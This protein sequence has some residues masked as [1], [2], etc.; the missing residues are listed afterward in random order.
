MPHHRGPV[1]VTHT[2][3]ISAS[4]GDAA[5]GGMERHVLDLVGS[6]VARGVD[7]ELLVL[8]SES[9]ERVFARLDAL[10]TRVPV[11]L[12]WLDQRRPLWTARRRFPLQALA[13]ARA[14]AARSSRLLHIHVGVADFLQV[15]VARLFGN[16][17]V[18]SQHS[19]T[20]AFRRR[21]W[22]AAMRI[23]DPLV[24]RYIAV[25]DA[26]R[27]SLIDDVGIAEQKIRLVDYGIPP[28][29]P[30]HD[31]ATLRAALGL[32][33]GAFVVGYLG[34]LV[35]MKN[36]DCLVEAVARVPEVFLAI[37]GD[38]ADRDAIEAHAR[39][40]GAKNVRFLGYRTDSRE[41][42]TAF[43][44]AVLVSDWEGKPLSLIEAMLAGVPVLG[45]A[46][47]GTSEALLHGA[48]GLLVPRRDVDALAIA[49]RRAA[50]APAEM[51]ML[52]ARACQHATDAFSSARMTDEVVRV[53][54]DVW[55]TKRGGA[56]HL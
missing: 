38:G 2:L 10:R 1:R 13:L 49:L 46:V 30:S 20:P 17:V 35:A 9:N 32:P 12:C 41:I 21:H 40:L 16:G 23:A 52:A 29:E 42:V 24:D 45:S 53:Y 3:P 18:V 43:D 56:A 27:R 34:R 22:R 55:D 4:L 39:E 7:A 14:F 6:L 28:F 44:L 33:Q 54:Q 51:A 37:I 8:L 5:F 50:S 25:S 15:P 47:A 31:K 11:S 48:C 19:A 26:V 36:V